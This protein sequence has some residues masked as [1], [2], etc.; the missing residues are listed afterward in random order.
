MSL[1]RSLSQF[2]GVAAIKISLLRSCRNA[3]DGSN[4]CGLKHK[5]D[6]ISCAANECPYIGLLKVVHD[7]DVIYPA[8]PTDGTSS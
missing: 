4:H 5:A 6:N 7:N 1:L 2:F 3:T 8:V